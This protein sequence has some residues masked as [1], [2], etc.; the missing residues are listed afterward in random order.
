V[1]DVVREEFEPHG[2]SV[3]ALHIGF[4]D[5]DMVADIDAMKA[6]PAIIAGIAFD[7]VED[8]AI[9]VLTDETTREA[10]LGL[11]RAPCPM[12]RCAHLITSSSLGDSEA[13]DHGLPRCTS[14]F[15]IGVH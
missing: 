1:T 9:E 10:E 4:M 12:A 2:V 7:G 5:T 3:T 6:D 8:S 15:Q 13:L 14:R 11:R